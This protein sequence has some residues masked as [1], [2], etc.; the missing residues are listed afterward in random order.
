MGFKGGFSSMRGG[1]RVNR[2]KV[3]GVRGV[4]LEGCCSGYG[5]VE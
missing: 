4:G 2:G 1:G 5:C 3:G